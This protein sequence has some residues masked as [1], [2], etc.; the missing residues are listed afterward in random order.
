MFKLGDIVRAYN[1]KGQD[2][3]IVSKIVKIGQSAA[4][5]ETLYGLENGYQYPERWLRLVKE[6][7]M[8]EV[9][10]LVKYIN[11]ESIYEIESIISKTH[12]K[13]RHLKSNRLYDMD[14]TERLVKLKFKVGDKVKVISGEYKDNISTITG[15]NISSAT[16]NL[17]Y[18][19]KDSPIGFME[20]LLELVTEESPKF[21]KGDLV[22]ID[23]NKT[24]NT[25]YL[26][27]VFQVISTNNENAVCSESSLATHS[28][29]KKTLSKFKFQPNDV[30][31]VTNICNSNYKKIFTI[32]SVRF[33]NGD[34]EYKSNG[35]DIWYAEFE[36]STLTVDAKIAE[37]IAIKIND[38]DIEETISYDIKV[39]KSVYDS[40]EKKVSEIIDTYINNN[41][42][43]QNQN[44]ENRLQEEGTL[45]LR[46]DEQERVGIHGRRHQVASFNPYSNGILQE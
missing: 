10:D 17:Y 23:P 34:I 1:S 16:G 18:S 39:D 41:N 40:F 28:F 26:Y 42:L 38:A 33:N 32:S 19:V 4:T 12:I 14:S 29:S 46:R 9:N 30:V 31:Q 5:G 43:N 2:P 25:S 27:K 22:Y 6:N 3:G 15:A 21:K 11:G 35:S 20:Y 8:F 13:I 37:N 7:N 44:D 45:E 24:T 36:L